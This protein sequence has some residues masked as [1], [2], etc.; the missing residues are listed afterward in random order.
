MPTLALK[1]LQ[2]FVQ[3][4]LVVVI[5]RANRYPLVR[6]RCTVDSGGSN[7]QNFTCRIGFFVVLSTL[8]KRNC[9]LLSPCC[10]HH[11]FTESGGDR[12]LL[13]LGEFNL[14]S[15]VTT[16]LVISNTSF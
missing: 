14:N 1:I 11:L 16:V 13:H 2:N 6:T 3:K 5:W 8:T 10:R 15:F 4:L 9:G 7:K 12:V